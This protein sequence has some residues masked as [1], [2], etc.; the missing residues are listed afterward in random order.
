M[1]NTKSAAK[2]MRASRRKR[3]INLV[4]IGKYKYAVKAV[5][6]A[7]A[8]KKK[9]EAQKAL[10]LAFAQL[11]KAAKKHVIHPNKAARLKSRLTMAIAKI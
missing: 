2:A 6:K 4:T 3:A 11:D 1:P 8:A 5:R 7:I 9:E 10:A